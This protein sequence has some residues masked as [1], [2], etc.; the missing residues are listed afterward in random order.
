MNY[1]DL[2]IWQ[3]SFKLSI[4]I[5]KLTNKFPKNE[6]FGLVSQIRRCAISIP[7]N[8]AEG[9][10]RYSKKYFLQF[11]RISMGSASELETQLLLSKEI[12]YT[13]DSDLIEINSLLLEVQ[14]I[15]STLIKKHSYKP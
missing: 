6:Q 4:L 11:L 7:S 10:S 12:K 3:K 1:K 2:I 9:F 8:I 15:L 13:E 14:K 5:Y